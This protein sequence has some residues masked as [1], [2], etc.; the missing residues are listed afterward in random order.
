MHHDLTL[1]ATFAMAI[2][3]AFIGG[4]IARR[5]GLPT[6]IGY[7]LAGFAIG[8]FTPGFVGDVN[9]ASQ[10]AEVGVI[11]MLFGVGLH[12]SLRDLW[13]VRRIAI[14]GAVLQMIIAT[15]LGLG[16]TQL[17]GWS[18]SA[19]LVLGLAISIASTVVLLRGL[20][21]NNLTTTEAGKVAIGW[22]VLEDLATVAILV[23]LPSL[24]GGADG[25]ASSDALSSIVLALVKTALFVFLI[26]IVG[27]RFMPWLLQRI[28]DTGSR[29]L[30]ILAVTAV[31]LG[32]AFGAAELF[33][34]SLALGA[35]L[36]GVVIG[37]SDIGHKAGEE[38]IPFR[39]MF[40][41]LFFVSVGMLVNPAVIWANAGQVIALTVLIVVGKS[42]ATLIIGRLLPADNRTTAVVAMGLS[43]IGEFSF[44][45]GQAGV[46]LGILASEQY[47]LLLA[48]ALL[49]III[50]PLML[51]AIPGLERLLDSISVR[52]PQ[53]SRQPESLQAEA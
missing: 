10:L 6:L 2:V 17:W 43:Q 40:S 37:E 8:P 22:L 44:I 34:V 33:G 21:D 3:T 18:V 45:V 39:D 13:R 35:F 41:V 32:T 25:S 51:R 15:L 16:L 12:F 1:L 23:I 42:A 53:Q 11:F 28:S 27:A 14:P 46:A 52:H 20:D 19:G 26:L 30:F 48:G 7:L 49:S 31:A 47:S 24:V 9:A 38:I 5:L 50:N 4:I 36:A 29:E